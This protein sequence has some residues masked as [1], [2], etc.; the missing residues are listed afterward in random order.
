[1]S[2]KIAVSRPGDDDVLLSLNWHRN[3]FGLC[4]FM[5]DNIGDRIRSLYHIC[6]D[7]AY[8]K[9]K[10]L[11]RSKFLRIVNDYQ[12]RLQPKKIAH[13]FF[14]FRSFVQFLEQFPK[15]MVLPVQ[16]AGIMGDYRFEWFGSSKLAINVAQFQSYGKELGWDDMPVLDWYKQWFAK[17]VKLVEVMQDPDVEVW[18]ER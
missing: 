14:S 17:L 7:Y 13:F 11:N 16:E 18:I 6:N 5:E 3:P 2:Y 8:G 9:E 12:T 10:N 1:M 4:S 15:A